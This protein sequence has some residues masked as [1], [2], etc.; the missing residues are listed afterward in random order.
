M[1]SDSVFP[2]RY[3]KSEEI[4]HDLT[5]TIKKV[6]LE[7]M[8]TKDRGEQSK[9]VVYFV[10]QPKGFVCN[11]TNWSIIARAYGDE[12]DD[13]AGKQITLG[14]MDVEAFGDVV[15][16]IRVRPPAK[17]RKG[18]APKAAVVTGEQAR[19]ELQQRGEIAP[20][21]ESD[22]KEAVQ[23]YWRTAKGY[24]L[25]QKQGLK[26]LEDH[27]GDFGKATAFLEADNAMPPD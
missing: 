20:P 27:G 7:T 26:I 14:V 13:W 16:A 10:E 23:L 22:K 9:P 21:S 15:S 19:A 12:S 18:P 6:V 8:E 3:L 24:G 11:K 4:E 5:L 2:S 1:K 25:N 17:P